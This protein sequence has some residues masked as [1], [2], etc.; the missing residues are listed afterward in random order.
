[1]VGDRPD[2]AASRI[3]IDATATNT[4]ASGTRW[5][6]SERARSESRFSRVKKFDF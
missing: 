6:G 3:K 4:H 2:L 1:M 5:R